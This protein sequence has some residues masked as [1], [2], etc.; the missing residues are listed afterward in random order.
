MSYSLSLMRKAVTRGPRALCRRVWTLLMQFTSFLRAGALWSRTLILFIVPGEEFIGGGMFSIYNLY[1]MSIRMRE[2]HQGS[3]IMCFCPGRRLPRW[4]NTTIDSGITIC[5]LEFALRAS[6]RARKL[7]IH[8]P[9]YLLQDFVE[10]VGIEKLERLSKRRGMRLNILN[11]N[12]T[13][14]P[15][16]PFIEKL[17]KALPGVTCTCA[18]PSYSTLEYQEKL[19]VPVHHLPGWTYPRE[20]VVSAYEEKENIFLVSPDR[21]EWREPVLSLIGRELP[22]FRIQV[23]FNMPFEEYL[24][25]AQRAKFSLTFGEGLDDYFIGVFLR[26]GIGFA[27]YNEE[28]FTAQFHDART[29]YPDWETLMHNLVSDVRF[30]DK[31]DAYEAINA[32]VRAQLEGVWSSS[33]TIQRLRDFYEGK[34]SLL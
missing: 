5:P 3:V 24:K 16:L 8:V 34:F 31:K 6:V 29:V 9:E 13:L 17:R 20:P 26:G 10:Q 27:V 33:R 12:V 15:P 1:R 22:Q 18:H 25:L 32:P 30:L 14:M 2:V 19:G 21:S 23:V 7:L 4:R 11:Q 28:F